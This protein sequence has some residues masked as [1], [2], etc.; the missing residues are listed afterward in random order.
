[1]RG[2][3]DIILACVFRPFIIKPSFRSKS[4]KHYYTTIGYI[5]LI[6]SYSIR[7][8]RHPSVRMS[9]RRHVGLIGTPRNKSKSFFTVTSTLIGKSKNVNHLNSTRPVAGCSRRKLPLLQ[10]IPSQ[11]K[12]AWLKFTSQEDERQYARKAPWALY[13]VT[14]R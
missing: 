11:A 5:N 6:N 10:G 13:L 2:V 12:R 8:Q 9:I 4:C 7:T 3:F 1:M 14:H